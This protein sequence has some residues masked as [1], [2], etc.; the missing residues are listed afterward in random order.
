MRCGVNCS[1]CRIAARQG[2][3]VS[4]GYTA[5]IRSGTSMLLR[6]KVSCLGLARRGGVYT[7]PAGNP[8]ESCRATGYLGLD[9]EKSGEIQKSKG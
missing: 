2:V 7:R 5:P 3:A 1:L 6:L 9:S 8:V 4:G